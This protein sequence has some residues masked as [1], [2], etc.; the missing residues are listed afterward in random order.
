MESIIVQAVVLLLDIIVFG[1]GM[2]TEQG[3]SRA[4]VTPDVAKEYDYCI[5]DSDIANRPPVTASE[6]QRSTTTPS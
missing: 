3:W 6:A 4:P 1:L 2:A 5:Y